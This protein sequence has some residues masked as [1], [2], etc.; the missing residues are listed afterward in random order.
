MNAPASTSRSAWLPITPRGVA[1]FAGASLGRLLL[2][3]LFFALIAA[4]AF[5]WFL[6]TAWVPSIREAISQSPSGAQIQGGVLEWPGDSPAI[7]AEGHFLAFSVDLEHSGERISTSHLQVEFGKRD[8]QVS[9]LLGVLDVPAL[10]NTSYPA[11]NVIA[12]DRAELE[13]WWGAREP[14]FV[15]LAAAGLVIYLM[16]SWALLATIYSLPA[17]LVGFFANRAVDW[18]GSWR[19]AGAALMP[20][21]LMASVV[22][23]LYGLRAF[24]LVKFGFAFGLHVVVGWI[25]IFVSPLFLPRNPEVPVAEK[26]PF[27]GKK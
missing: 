2:V 20:G 6:R 26:N 22:I 19:L 17:W 10:V 27:D 4:T 9:S 25:Y 14:F 3:Q 23:V 1:A 16:I 12:L 24:D 11:T 8:W 7:L 18:R 15:F 13:P 5:G 21:A